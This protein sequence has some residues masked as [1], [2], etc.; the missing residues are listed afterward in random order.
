MGFVHPTLVGGVERLSIIAAMKQSCASSGWRWLAAVLSVS[1]V[2]S[3]C[4]PALDWRTVRPEGAPGLQSVFPCKP[5]QVERTLSVP[6]L[7]GPPVRMH[8]A[9][10]KVGETLWALTYFDAQDIT[11][12]SPAL[13]ANSQALRD[14]LNAAAARAKTPPSLVEAVDLGPATMAGMTPNPLARHWRLSGQRP[15]ANGEN[16][17]FEVQAWHF[18]HGL[19]VF[20]A[21]VWRPVPPVNAKESTEAVATF[22]QGFKFSE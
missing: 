22:V 13:A 4:S 19:M 1:L 14:N 16:A 6:G 7:S 18:S 11:R 2:A 15:N 10:C 21:T 3:A 12:V 17:A 5:D 20:Q 9:S 8:L